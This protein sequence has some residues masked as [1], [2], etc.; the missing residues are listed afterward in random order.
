MTG[1]FMAALS[2]QLD[3]RHVDPA[4]LAPALQRAFGKLH[5][6]GAFQ[7]RVFV[8]RAFADVANEQ[9]PLLLETVVVGEIVRQLRPVAIKIV[10][11]FLVGIP[12]RPRRRLAGLDL[13][14]GWAGDRRAVGAV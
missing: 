6:L 5:A 7:Q 3:R 4:A 8:G 1:L 9:L 12:D 2:S 11:P 10:Q 13:A 14:F